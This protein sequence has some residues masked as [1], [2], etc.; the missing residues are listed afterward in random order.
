MPRRHGYTSEHRTHLRGVGRVRRTPRR[1]ATRVVGWSP[2]PAFRRRVPTWRPLELHHRVPAAAPAVSRPTPAELVRGPPPVEHSRRACAVRRPERP[3]RAAHRSV[4]AP[5]ARL[6][7][8]V[9]LHEPERSVSRHD[10]VRNRGRL[11]RP[12]SDHRDRADASPCARC[13][14]LVR[15][16]GRQS[17]CSPGTLRGRAH[18]DTPRQDRRGRHI[19]ITAGQIPRPSLPTGW[20]GTPT[21]V[22][23]VST[24]ALRRSS[25][26]I[27]WSRSLNFWI[28]PV[29]VIGNSSTEI[30]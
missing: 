10:R 2:R 7:P 6:A 26:S 12:S 4:R 8:L 15:T 9:L 11:L 24:T 16:T 5:R 29:T 25:H 13:R 28:L 30:T 1:R 20:R 17:S 18:L 22:Y 27:A 3:A 21:G 14:T 23:A 19:A